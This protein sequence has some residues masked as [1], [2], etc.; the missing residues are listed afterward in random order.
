MNDMSSNSYYKYSVDEVQFVEVYKSESEKYLKN[1]PLFIAGIVCS[2]ML[3][4]AFSFFI[5]TPRE[6]SLL[7][8]NRELQMA[9]QE[10]GKEVQGL[11]N[12]FD[13]LRNK[14]DSLY[15]MILGA[16]PVPATVRQAGIGGIPLNKLDITLEFGASPHALNDQINELLPKALVLNY[17]FNETIKLAQK[18]IKRLKFIPAIM[19]VYNKNL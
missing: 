16:E 13:V 11:E 19:P 15:R 9:F 2:L 12:T 1:Y 6:Y 7:Q 14:D 3:L 17:S 4:A 18:N 8:Q 5:P 10:L